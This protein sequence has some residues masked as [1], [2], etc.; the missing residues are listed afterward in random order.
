MEKRVICCDRILETNDKFDL[1]DVRKMFVPMNI[2]DVLNLIYQSKKKS[3][4]QLR[5]NGSHNILI[6]RGFAANLY[7]HI[8]KSR[9]TGWYADVSRYSWSKVCYGELIFSAEV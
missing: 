6:V 3:E 1:L 4:I 8:F 7:V 9:H 2:S 5:D